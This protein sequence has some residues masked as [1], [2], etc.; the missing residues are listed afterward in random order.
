MR[1]HGMGKLHAHMPQPAKANNADFLS[2]PN[3]PMLERR[4]GRDP[5]TKQRRGGRRV[6]IARHA[7]DESLIDRDFVGVAAEGHL[8]RRAADFV[9]VAVGSG[10]AVVTIL[11]QPFVAGR[12]MPAAID[13][14]TDAN[15]IAN[16]EFLTLSPMAA[17]RPTISCPGTNGYW[18][19]CH[20]LRAE[21]MSEWQ[22][23]Q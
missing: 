6:E 21:W 4:I 5:G 8:V 7:Q 15:H 20:S 11:L 16:L 23:P 9:F 17:T 22:M 13:Q 1:A 18:V 14:A 10:E 19:L 2:W 3:L 12:A